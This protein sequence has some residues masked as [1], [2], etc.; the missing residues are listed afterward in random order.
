LAS[1]QP[2]LEIVAGTDACT[3]ITGYLPESAGVSKDLESQ[4]K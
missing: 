1:I 3:E 2:I 4:I